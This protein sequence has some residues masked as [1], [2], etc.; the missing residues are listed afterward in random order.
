MVALQGENTLGIGYLNWYIPRL[1]EQRKHDLGHS[2]L[3]Y[4]WNF[5]ELME[6][7]IFEIGKHHIMD[8]IDPRIFVA[9]KE[10]SLLNK[11]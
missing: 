2:G 1:K 4:H 6:D 8:K 10:E 9:K 7:E 5:A 3:Q 11:S